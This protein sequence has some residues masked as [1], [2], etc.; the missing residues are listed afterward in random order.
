MSGVYLYLHLCKQPSIQ[1]EKQKRTQAS[2]GGPWGQYA[3]P[4]S[5]PHPG[6]ESL[7]ITLCPEQSLTKKTTGGQRGMPESGSE[8]CR[9]LT[10]FYVIS[11]QISAIPDVLLWHH[12]VMMRRCWLDISEANQVFVLKGK[13]QALGQF[14]KALRL[15]QQKAPTA[16]GSFCHE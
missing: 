1:A 7:S 15:H 2:L 5:H 13:P 4:G 14:L 9:A 10:Q 16:K 8:R 3:K 11:A 12:E 6:N